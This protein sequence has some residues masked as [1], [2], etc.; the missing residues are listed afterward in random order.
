GARRHGRRRAQREASGTRVPPRRP[1]RPAT[2]GIGAAAGRGRRM[3]SPVGHVWTSML[4]RWRSDP[5]FA[6]AL[7]A[8]GGALVL[9]ALAGVMVLRR[10]DPV[11]VLATL[12]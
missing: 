3:R 4:E 12:L 2:T 9:L 1:S 7:V 6:R 8:C 10:A 11:E 5:R